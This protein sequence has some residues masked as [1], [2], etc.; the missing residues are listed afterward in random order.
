MSNTVRI[1]AGKTPVRRHFIREW[2]AHRH[3]RQR[4]IVRELGV[5]KGLVSRWFGGTLPSEQ[6]LEGLADLFQTTTDSLFRDPGDD[7]LAKFFR[8]RSDDEKERARR[9]LEEAFPSRTGTR[10]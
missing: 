1:H 2:A 9:I 4:D 7:W 5:D 3:L 8:E 6:Y 10:G